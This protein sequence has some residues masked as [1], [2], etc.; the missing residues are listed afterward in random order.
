MQQVSKQI[1]VG[2]AP[3]ASQ[4]VYVYTNAAMNNLAAIFNPNDGTPL[5]NPLHTSGTGWLYFQAKTGL[6][7][8]FASA[9]DPTEAIASTGSPS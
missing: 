2:G 1:F 9:M 8:Y 5:Q 4:R 6:N 3:F 7:F